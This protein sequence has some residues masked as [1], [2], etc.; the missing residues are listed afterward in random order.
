MEQPP[1]LFGS[2]GSAAP[3]ECLGQTFASDEARR[4]HFRALLRD[5]LHDPAFRAS[6]G[7]PNASD[8]DILS[9]S[10]PPYFTACPNPFLADFIRQASTHYDPTI[11][12]YQREP[13]AFDV[14]EGKSDPVYN[15]H[16]YHTKVPHKAILRYVLHYTEPGDVVLDGFC[17]TGMT[18]VASQL[19]GDRATVEALGYTVGADGTIL[20][21]GSKP[22]SRL[23]VRRAVLGDLSPAAAFIAATYN[24]PIDAPSFKKEAQRVL[25]QVEAEWG[26]MYRTLHEPSGEQRARAL[27]QV[28]RRGQE[29]DATLP[30]GR[31]VYTIWSDVFLCPECG[32]E[33]VFW[34]AAVDQE[35]GKVREQFPCPTCQSQ[36]TRRRL[37]RA[38]GAVHDPALNA[39]VQQARQVPVLLNYTHGKGRYRKVPDEVDWAV[40]EEIDKV[41][42][43]LWFPA[44]RMPDGEE[45]RRNDGA[46]ITHTHH[47][48][49]RRN[50]YTLASLWA[51]SQT[52]AHRWLVTGIMQRASR[53][54]QI[55]IS[56]IGG[57]KAGEGGATAGHR[58]GT[59]YIPSNQVEFHPCELFKERLTIAAK[60]HAALRTTPGGFCLGVTPASRAELPDNSVDYIFTDPPF[61]GNIMY[62]E[63]NTIWEGW[64]RVRTNNGPEAVENSVQHKDLA[65]YQRLMAESFR[66][67]HRVLK[68]GRWITVEF[69]NSRNRVWLAIQEALQHA[70]FVVADVRILDKKIMTHT[71][72]TAAGS[73]NK[74]LT[75]TAYKPAATVE[76]MAEIQAGTVET[77]WAFIT[78]HLGQLPVFVRRG[79]RAEAIPER[80]ATFLFDRMVAFHVQR[81]LAVPLSASEFYAGLDDRFLLRD[82]MYFLP[83]QIVDYDRLRVAVQGVEQVELF[84]SDEKSAIQWVRRQLGERPRRYS[85]LAPLY[86]SQAQ[87]VWAEHEVPIELSTILEEGFIKDDGSDDASLRDCWRLPDPRNARDLERLRLQQLLRE[88]DEYREMEGPLPVV[89]TEAV[90]AGFKAAYDRKD[91]ATILRLAPR[92]PESVQE[93]AD[94]LMYVDVAS[95]RSGG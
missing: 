8:E 62:S 24:T 74:D 86:M 30:W 39:I 68:P 63:L 17:G 52:A 53:Q 48:F 83:E 15:A 27:E 22:P 65:A 21:R 33:V 32:G 67:Y 42:P 70:G 79:N 81:S 40:L 14:G 5:R 2:S 16:G 88:F 91:Y 28:G 84:V 95:M 29:P 38:L 46:G 64:L 20:D 7:F 66:E 87:K 59:L 57:P 73:V 3:V 9:L 78:S 94:L 89:R 31:I 37:E 56:R 51:R 72:R 18:G 6:D 19:C 61:G 11:D 92:L 71:Q 54:H 1:S 85:D 44:E 23:G 77:A 12:N 82:E 43:T 41:R 90:R 55:A 45:A 47:F 34:N 93:D 58:R 60:A 76:R 50:L 25:R 69:H 26:W 36:L 75:I 4:D 13:F 49:T 10:D 80:Q 35:A